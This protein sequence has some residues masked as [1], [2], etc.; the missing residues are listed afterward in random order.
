MNR[1]RFLGAGAAVLGAGAVGALAGPATARL[2]AE[3]RP[4][5]LLSSEVPLPA[6]FQ[7]PL[8]VPAVLAPVHSDATAD[9]YE[10]TQQIA[11]LEIL[12]GLRTEAWTYGGTFPG[13]TLVARS[14]REMMVRHRNELAVPTV[15]H[16]HGGHTPAES[17]GYPVDLLLPVGSSA[18]R[19]TWAAHADHADH[20]DH[21]TAGMA[22]MVGMAGMGAADRSRTVTGERTHTYPGRQRAATLWYHDH[23]MGFT[24]PAVWRGLAGFHLVRDEEEDAL[25]LPRGERELPLMLA[26]RSFAAD[27]SFAYPALDAALAVPGVTEDYMNG[28]LGDIVLVNGAP[29]PRAEVDRA[30]YRLRVLNASNARLYR[31]E[32]DPQPSGGGALVQIG[33]DGGLLEQPIAHDAVEIAPAERF[34]LVVDFSRYP[35]GT[36][37]RL[38]NRFGSGRT[39]E[40]MLFDV[41][42]RPVRDDSTVP[43]RLCTLERLDPAAAVTTRTFGFRRSRNAG[44]TINNQ[45]YE[46]GRSLARPA[47]GSTE[48][49]RFFSDVHHPVHV[50]LNS[51]QVL[52]RNGKDPGPYDAGWKDTVDLR[53]AEAV[54]VLVRFTD[55]AGTYMLHCHNLE[56]EDMAMMADFVVE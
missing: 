25:P 28:V 40:V 35:A 53:P 6:A 32:L 5:R 30:R 15:V 52:S 23:R 29:W 16:L 11:R 51:F 46:P 39:E 27:G 3:A 22:G 7:V 47:L 54:Q 9:H 34:D 37:V 26:D 12:P 56:H 48:I 50:H 18:D 21:T 42:S 13:P 45:P 24:G 10:I 2:L 49:W 19:S 17:D 41:S 43:E 31:L 38:M 33:G 14:G 8:P 55:Y 36:Q 1:R 44:W 4:G 20:A